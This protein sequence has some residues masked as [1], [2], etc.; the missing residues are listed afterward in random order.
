[1]GQKVAV[2]LPDGKLIK[3]KIIEIIRGGKS[4]CYLV[5]YQNAHALV[6]ERDI[7]QKV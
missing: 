5:Q 2:Y 6:A 1:V 7:I 4:Y 3:A